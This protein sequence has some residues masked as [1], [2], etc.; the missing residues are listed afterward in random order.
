MNPMDENLPE[1]N[2]RE[3][4]ENF[5]KLLE[6]T[7]IRNE[8]FA[9][10]DKVRGTVVFIS[11]ENVFIDISGKSEAVAEVKEFL[12]ESG[13]LT[14][15]KGDSIDAYIVSMNAGEILVSTNIG[16]GHANL[17]LLR[18]A[19]QFNIPIEGTILDTV[20]GGYAVSVSGINCFCPY[21]QV[22]I[23]SPPDPESLLKQTFE[24]QI[25]EFSE[26]GKNIILS[27][28]VLLE[29]YREEQLKQLRETI[30]EGDII[31]GKVVSIQNFGIFA[32]IGGTEALIPKSEISWS[33][34]PCLESFHIGETVQAKII[35]I[36]WEH[37][38][39]GLSI[40]QLNPE[41][42]EN[43]EQYHAGQQVNG[44]VMNI[45]R[46]G[47]FVEL[48]PGLEGFIPL[49]RMSLIK[50]INKPE[51]V[52]AIGDNISVR[53]LEI[54][55]DDKKMLL[56]LI[57]DEPDPWL[58][59]TDSLL[60]KAHSATIE[61]SRDAGLTVRLSNGM[62]GF[63]PA[64]EVIQRKCDLQKA[65]PVGSGIKVAIKDIIKEE[66]KLI[67]SERR[68]VKR[69]EMEEYKKYMSGSSEGQESDSTI[70]NI[71]KDTFAEIRKKMEEE[72]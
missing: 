12:N 3:E 32:D 23:K 6:G 22:D 62:A 47:A 19:H 57:T 50:H 61:S 67:L 52:L 60:E 43:I 36:D 9:V 40:K 13:D 8:T 2:D 33:R 34:R 41:P 56:E 69:E 46:K 26:R 71:F 7:P 42:W 72:K 11:D 24:F 53:I 5:E 64:S 49:S 55:P 38:K 18:K 17:E 59:P 63:V 20:K 54:N 15:T 27:R 66:R 37:E 51:D 68:A 28:K 45:I 31:S 4:E 1:I 10:G 39:I 25:I 65:Y 16:R 14:I 30:A 48:E 35:S 58:A 21:S 29:K 70:G 44:T